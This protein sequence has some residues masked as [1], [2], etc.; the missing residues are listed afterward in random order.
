[1]GYR[2]FV[3]GLLALEYAGVK[4]TLA[5]P[6]WSLKRAQLPALFPLLP[7]GEQAPLEMGGN[8]ALATARA[9]LMVAM[10]P[11]GQ[12][13]RPTNYAGAL[14]MMD[15]VR[16][17][18]SQAKVGRGKLSWEIRMEGIEV[19]GTMFWGIVIDVE[20]RV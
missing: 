4:T 6:P 2:E 17:T 3:E 20:G 8:V 12:G 7:T 9:T 19:A 13:W 5:E 18:L 16:E 11:L 10:E 15:S 14:D 1:M